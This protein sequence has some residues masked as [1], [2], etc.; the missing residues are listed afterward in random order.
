MSDFPFRQF[1]F[2]PIYC[3]LAYKTLKRTYLIYIYIIYMHAFFTTPMIYYGRY[4]KEEGLELFQTFL[5]FRIHSFL[6]TFL[7]HF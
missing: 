2:T 3:M 6:S 5:L 4:K 1:S 7:L